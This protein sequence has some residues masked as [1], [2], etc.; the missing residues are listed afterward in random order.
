MASPHER[1]GRG[2]RRRTAA[3]QSQHHHR[4]T[5]T[6]AAEA[7]A[8]VAAAATDAEEVGGAPVCEGAKPV[9][10]RAAF[11]G[12]RADCLEPQKGAPAHVSRLS[13]VA[14]LPERILKRCS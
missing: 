14:H 8:A 9:A 3:G 2:E 10:L 5:S 11:E 13:G 7:E 6:A 4:C 12:Q 1:A